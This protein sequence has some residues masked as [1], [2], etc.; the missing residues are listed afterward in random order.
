M[1]FGCF[2]DDFEMILGWFENDGGERKLEKEKENW[3]RGG[4]RKLETEEEKESWKRGRSGVDTSW[5]FL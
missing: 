5:G 3:K 1:I 2:W 4:K